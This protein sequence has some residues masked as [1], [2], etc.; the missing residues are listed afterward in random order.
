MFFSTPFYLL[1]PF[2]PD[3]SE[4]PLSSF[5]TPYPSYRTRNRFAFLLKALSEIRLSPFFP[6]Q[7]QILRLPIRDSL[8][9]RTSWGLAANRGS[10]FSRTPFFLLPGPWGLP[11]FFLTEAVKF[12]HVLHAPYLRNPCFHSHRSI[13]CVTL[14]QAPI[15]F[16][17]FRPRCFLRTLRS[18]FAAFMVPDSPAR[19]TLSREHHPSASGI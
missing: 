18:A 6:P 17:E 7:R 14:L 15:H 13:T 19:F 1:F 8:S 16:F 12:P 11:P 2:A 3:F 5:L 4:A 9:P 10:V